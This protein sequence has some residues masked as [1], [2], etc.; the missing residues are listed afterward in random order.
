MSLYQRGKSWYYNFTYRGQRYNECIGPVSKTRAKE[1]EQCKRTE[2]IEGRFVPLASKPSPQLSDFVPEYFAYY[3]A[4]RRPMAARRHETSWHA[5]E[6]V[7][8]SRRLDEITTLCT[9][10]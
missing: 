5:I 9:G 6:P 3:R 1:V 10:G 7:F 8:G 2:V 4:N